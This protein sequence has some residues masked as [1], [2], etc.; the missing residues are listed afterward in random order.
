VSQQD[1]TAV[2]IA[3]PANAAAEDA[4]AALSARAIRLR[5]RA[6]HWQ[7]TQT[8]YVGQRL[9]YA[10]QALAD[11]PDETPW[12]LRK[13]RMLANV[14][15]RC[16]CMVH[17]DELLVGYNFSGGDDQQGLEM[18]A[19]K[20]DA[21]RRERIAAYLSTGLL[22]PAQVVAALSILDRLDGLTP[23]V[24]FAPEPEP[25]AA[26]AADEGLYWCHATAYNH[27]VIGYE[28]VLAQGFLAL[29]AEVRDRLATL[30][31]AGVAGLQARM[32]LES[33]LMVAEA[34]AEIGARYADCVH[35]LRQACADPARAAELAALE[36][37][38]R[39]VPAHPAR[40]FR[41]AHPQYMKERPV[42]TE[43]R[44]LM[45]KWP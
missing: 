15:R 14:I 45:E 41:E 35:E 32:A 17:D 5:E 4:P 42:E 7:E 8:A 6:V 12:M 21:A 39:Q 23:G 37:M 28:R 1:G 30:E 19:S 18:T 24:G 3:P 26:Q 34:A 36:D 22:T 33:M 2:V 9:F 40:T 16:A 11:C 10:L 38:L 13:S 29:A 27:T 31:I 43:F 20:P 25:L 44:F